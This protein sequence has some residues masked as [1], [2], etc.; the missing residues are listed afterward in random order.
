M[1]KHIFSAQYNTINRRFI[2]QWGLGSKSVRCNSFINL[3]RYVNRRLKRKFV[4]HLNDTTMSTIF[5]ASNVLYQEMYKFHIFTLH[6]KKKLAI[7]PS[8]WMFFLVVLF[9]FKT[10]LDPCGKGAGVNKLNGLIC[11][12]FI[13]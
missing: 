13:V 3:V 8:P 12:V 11:Q 9:T 6:C 7:F 2:L 1:L 10:N 5:D 4:E